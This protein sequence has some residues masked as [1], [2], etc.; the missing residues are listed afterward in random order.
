MD[1]GIQTDESKSQATRLCVVRRS[2]MS[3]LP[4]A[5]AAV[6]FLW[7]AHFGIA[8]IRVDLLSMAARQQI[9]QWAAARSGWTEAS[10]RQAEADVLAAIE[11]T[12]ANPV[13]H[14]AAATLY[15][16][17]GMAVWND[18]VPRRDFFT[19][20]R[21]HQE[22][23]LAE[24]PQNG[25]ALAGLALS[26]AALGSPLAEFHHTWADALTFAPHE[27]P[28]QDGLLFLVLGTWDQASP[29][30]RAWAVRV[31]EFAPPRRRE[32]MRALARQF[33][34]EAVFAAARQPSQP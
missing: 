30:M 18:A 29:S 21:V 1:A 9:G 24:R 3:R 2:A 16:V 31:F 13:L 28:V 14:D 19:K 6:I 11:V 34:R 23:S 32:S 4:I 15:A 27:Q 12:P 10:W 5:V 26:M 8:L 25:E 7:C 33:G 22:A 20:A 17:R